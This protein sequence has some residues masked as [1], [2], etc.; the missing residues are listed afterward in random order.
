VLQQ[1]AKVFNQIVV[2]KIPII[3]FIFVMFFGFYFLADA[4]AFTLPK[5]PSLPQ[6]NL[7]L[8]LRNSEGQ[9]VSY[10]ETD[11]ALITYLDLT[12]QF[13]D[14]VDNKITFVK[15]GKT[16]E[17]IQW[18]KTEYFDDVYQPNI[19]A[20]MYNGYATVMMYHG[21]YLSEPGDLITVY[22]DIIRIQP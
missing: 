4:N 10:F 12:H 18:Q 14:S 17:R 21:P 8:V 11:Y 3:L 22:W 9:L 19:Y 13:L 16:Y 20:L 15:D 1:A 7:Q 2:M 6:I 5:D